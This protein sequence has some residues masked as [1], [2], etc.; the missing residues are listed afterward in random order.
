MSNNLLLN[1]LSTWSSIFNGDLK[2]QTVNLNN[3]IAKGKIEGYKCT[4]YLEIIRFDFDL[5]KDH[6]FNA[7]A[8]IIGDDYIAV[9]LGNPINASLISY[10]KNI[11]KSFEM[12]SLGSF[13]ISSNSDLKWNFKKGKGRKMISLRLK[14]SVFENYLKKSSAL[15]D[16]CSIEKSFYVQDQFNPRMIEIFD[17]IFN[18]ENDDIFDIEMYE[19]YAKYLLTEFFKKVSER[20]EAQTGRQYDFNVKPILK[21]KE[22]LEDIIDKPVLIDDLTKEVGLSESRL[23]V[24]FKKVFGTTIHQYHQDIRLSKSQEMLLRGNKTMSMIALDLGYSSSS[25][26]SMV[27]KKRFN[28]SPKDFKRNPQYAVA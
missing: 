15:L 12:N 18:I 23:R 21:A 17:R 20:E 9:V 16:I 28:I 4:D 2:D 3:E 7:P 1:A 26:F 6:E 10:D 13:V 25:H 14:K 24:L 22:I 27:F 8:S 11:N 5:Y 19:V